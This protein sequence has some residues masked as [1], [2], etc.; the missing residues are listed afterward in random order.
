MMLHAFENTP[1]NPIG[2]SDVMAYK[3]GAISQVIV[4]RIKRPFDLRYCCG[5]SEGFG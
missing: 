2:C 5:C 4:Q 1:H 3:E